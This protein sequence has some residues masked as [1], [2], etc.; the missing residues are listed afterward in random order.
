[1]PRLNHER[2]VREGEIA[3]VAVRRVVPELRAHVALA[4]CLVAMPGYNTVCDILSYRPRA[5][6]VPRRSA[7]LEQPMRAERLHEW[8]LAH[9]VSGHE[10]SGSRLA[11]ALVRALGSGPPPP[12]PVPLTGLE[13]AVDVFERRHV[14]V[15]AA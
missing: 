8:G 13:S 11:A 6:L 4:D 12:A 1:M 5:V 2:L 14:R 3:G 10:V 7:S 15:R 9:V